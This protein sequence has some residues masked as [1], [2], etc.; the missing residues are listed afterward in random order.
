MR[1]LLKKRG[2][3]SLGMNIT[4]WHWRFCVLHRHALAVHDGKDRPQALRSVVPMKHVLQIVPATVQE[5]GGRTFA[6]AIHTSL[7]RTWTFCCMSEED[8]HAWVTALRAVCTLTHG[9][10]LTQVL[11]ESVS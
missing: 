3:S 1:G 8:V 7:G 2:G 9:A 4:T 10:G 6:F 11:S 5:S